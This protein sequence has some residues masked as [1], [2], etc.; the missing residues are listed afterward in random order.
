MIAA[1]EWFQKSETFFLPETFTEKCILSNCGE[2]YQ[3]SKTMTWKT[4]LIQQRTSAGEKW[5]VLDKANHHTLTQL[6]SILS[7]EEK[8]EGRNP[9]KQTITAV[10]TKSRLIDAVIAGKGYLTKYETLYVL[11]LSVC[12]YIYAHHQMCHSL[13]CLTHM[14]I[15]IRRSYVSHSS[16]ELG[17]LQKKKDKMLLVQHLWIGNWVNYYWKMELFHSGTFPNA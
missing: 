9:S 8:T 3:H 7:P 2:H 4:L 15:N 12:S 1:T 10:Q 14:N 13:S 17:C 16:F 6:S 5:K 11:I